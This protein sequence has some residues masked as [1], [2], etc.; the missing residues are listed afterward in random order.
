MTTRTETP[1]IRA[2]LAQYAWLYRGLRRIFGARPAIAGFVVVFGALAMWSLA[3]P[4]FAA[5]DEPAQVVKAVAAVRG[6]LIGTPV[7]ALGKAYTQVH[8]P[9]TFNNAYVIPKCFAFYSAKPAGCGPRLHVQSG[10]ATM[11]TYVGRYPPL[12]YLVAGLP[13]WLHR[14]GA[15]LY[16]MRLCSAAGT[17]LLLVCAFISAARSGRARLL[18]PGVAL[19][20]TPTV[21]FLGS[22]VNPSGWEISAAACVWASGLVYFGEPERRDR[23]LLIR[24][25]FSAAVLVQLRGLSPVLLAVI[26]VFLAFVAGWRQ[27]RELARRRDVRIGAAIIAAFGIFAVIWIVAAD[28]LSVTKGAFQVSPTASNWAV[29]KTSFRGGLDQFHQMVGLFGWNDTTAPNF[30]NY[31]WLVLV[32]ALVLAGLVQREWRKSVLLVCLCIVVIAFPAALTYTQARSLGYVGQARYVMPLVVGVPILAGYLAPQ[33]PRF[34]RPAMLVGGLALTVA[35]CATFVH[36]LHRYRTGL[37]TPLFS[38]N[39]KFTPPISTIAVLLIFGV[40]AVCF[41]LWWW[42]LA[43]AAEDHREVVG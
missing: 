9:A 4:E 39:G 17:A 29:F 5:P 10:T 31:I 27:L 41:W 1:G 6:N 11:Q 20:V 28:S 19:A 18:I 22:V 8:I 23:W 36:V 7:P 3:T 30:A 2:E 37:G 25:V 16:L 34:L 38:T 15:D 43:A 32:A 13:S 35:Q 42:A 21:L 33:R 12:Y 24:L 40:A 26:A 14:A